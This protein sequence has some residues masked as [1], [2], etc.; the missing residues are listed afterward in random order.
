LLYSSQTNLPCNFSR[1]NPINAGKIKSEELG[2]TVT[3]KDQSQ[4]I[5]NEVKK[6]GLLYDSSNEIELRKGDY[7]VFYFSKRRKRNYE[8]T[9]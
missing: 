7:V 4:S 6:N 1:Y 3:V 9:D 5:T 8:I 2:I